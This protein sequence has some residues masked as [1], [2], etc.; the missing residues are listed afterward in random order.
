MQ[1][2]DGH[3][4]HHEGTIRIEKRYS[5]GLNFSA[6][7][8]LAR[9]MQRTPGN[10][11]LNWA[12]LKTRT[13]FDQRHSLT[14]TMTYELPVGKGRRFLNR[15]GL[16]NLVAGGYD[17]VWTFS[18][19]SG[20]PAGMSIS[21]SPYSGSNFVYPS[22][23]P[24]YGNGYLLRD[25]SLRDNWQDLGGDRFTQ[26]NQNSTFTCG[27]DNSLVVNW[28]N[29]CMVRKNAFDIGNDNAMLFDQQRIFAATIS[30]S[31]EIPIKERLRVQLR[32]DFQNP[33]KWY[34]WGGLST[35]LNISSTANAKSFGTVASGNEGTTAAYGGAP[36]MN[37]TIAIKW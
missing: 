30:A 15:G 21:G 37:A 31:K 12:L 10:Q 20:Q 8:T 1:G 35:G 4:D 16:W 34:N 19:Y 9:T 25:P 3:S 24:N 29:S 32:L 23:M 5:R 27:Y 28:G 18:A 11:Y 26:S 22:Y 36:L 17:L 7:Y 2:N 13:N 14:G 33:F 6:F